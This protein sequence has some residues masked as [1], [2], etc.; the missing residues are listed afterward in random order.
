MNL[1]NKIL[2]PILDYLFRRIDKMLKGQ[3]AYVILD[4]AWVAFQNPVFA[5]K[6]IEWLKVFRKRNCAVVLATQNLMDATLN[7]GNLLTELIISTASKIFLPNAA[8]TKADFAVIY[9]KFGLNNKQIDIIASAIPKKHYYHYSSEGARL[10]ELAL[11]KLALAFVAV[12]TTPEINQIKNLIMTYGDD[13]VK[14]YLIY[15]NI[16][17]EQY[18]KYYNEDK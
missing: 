14:E 8:A 11:G 18:L 4:E 16:N 6:I 15:K 7:S 9:K 1:D 17:I 12:S 2:L 10:F 13:W 3:P 5:S